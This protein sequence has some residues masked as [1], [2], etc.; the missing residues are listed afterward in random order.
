MKDYF[1]ASFRNLIRIESEDLNIILTSSF[2]NIM[3][4]NAIINYLKQSG[5]IEKEE[6]HYICKRLSRGYLD[7]FMKTYREKPEVDR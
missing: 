3:C 5:I 1:Y 7:Q 2:G 4:L 6:G